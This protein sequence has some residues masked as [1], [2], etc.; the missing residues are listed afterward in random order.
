VCDCN[1]FFGTEITCT[2]ASALS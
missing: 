1:V 2:T